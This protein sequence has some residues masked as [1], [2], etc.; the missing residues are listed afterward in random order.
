MLT[1]T[2]RE[3]REALR[4]RAIRNWR[5]PAQELRAILC[6]VLAEEL[7]ALRAERAAELP[8]EPRKEVNAT[9]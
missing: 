1:I 6:E 9:P 8:D 4:R 2:E 3:L 5:K 7:E